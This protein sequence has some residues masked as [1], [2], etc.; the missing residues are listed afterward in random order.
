VS[1]G[2]SHVV[3]VVLLLGVTVVALGGLTATVGS[4]VDG[5]TAAADAARVADAFETDLRPVEQ[6]GHYTTR[7]RFTEG[8]LTTVDRDLRVL[9]AS[10][11]VETVPVGGLVYTAGTAR[12]AFV[13]GA[14][15]RGPPGSGWLVRDPPVTVTQHNGTL[16]VGAPRVNAS[17]QTV[18]GTDVAARLRTNVT[19]ARQRLPRDDYRFAIETATPGALARHFERLDMTTRTRDLDGDGVPSLV[20]GVGGQETVY[21]VVH[22]MHT[23]VAHG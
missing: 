17:G 4:V 19:H 16:V 1:R 10:G 5:Q 3:G 7:V 12:T 14:V 15:V 8:R 21:L 23:E 18:A 9:N 13:G 2:Q 6:T 20:V 11:V 22:D